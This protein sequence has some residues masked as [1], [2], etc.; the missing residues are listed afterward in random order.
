MRLLRLLPVV[1]AFLILLSGLLVA[2]GSI[3][4]RMN[5]IRIEQKLTDTGLA[6]NAPPIVAFTTVALG[7]FRGLVADWLWLRAN[8]MQEAGNYFE[9]VQLASWITKLQPRFTG[10]TSY[11]AW[12]MAYNVSVTF[13][14][15]ED[16]WRWVRRGVELIRDEALEYNPGDPELYRELG[17][18]YQ[19]KMGQE[20]DDA[21][22]YYK[23]EMAREMVKLFGP[24]PPDWQALADSPTTPAGLR[25]LLGDDHALWGL[26]AKEAKTLDDLE[27]EFVALGEF[28]DAM[29]EP[30]RRAR[31]ERVL[32][33]YFRSRWMGRVYKLDPARIARLN[34]L[35]GDLDWRLPQAHAVYWA[36]RGL[37]TADERVS[38]SCQR[39]I[40]Q[41]LNAAFK[42]GRLIYSKEL[43]LL[44]MT[45]NIALVD[46]VDQAYL[47]AGDTHGQRI[48]RG[49]YENF[50]VDAVV[51]LY[52]FGRTEKA[53]E[54][55]KKGR[56]RFGK[57]FGAPLD[58]FV[59]K[60]L[61]EDVAMA[62]Y[63]Q[64]QAAVQ[65]Y[66]LQTCTALVVGD[67][68]RAAMLERIAAGIWKKYMDDI[69]ESTV[70]RR[71]LPPFAQMKRNQVRQ[72]LELF[73]PNLAEVL[74]RN[75]P[76][77]FDPQVDEDAPPPPER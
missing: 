30:L 73:P 52:T 37:E 34:R 57:R 48:V 76:E 16:R 10:A 64:A 18:I 11:L 22:R 39:M 19:H 59:L 25:R 12:N 24:Y 4:S 60:E 51:I 77:G 47:S 55:L 65:A 54:Y 67:V 26:L 7:G 46:G 27:G 32:E 20:L 40:F 61:T 8:R 33:L 49:G 74:R 28:P 72:C 21:N 44:E 1:L 58:Q 35:H 5:A 6:E 3:Q 36:S 9:L 43:N 69:G 62:S 42:Q 50:L 17:W 13:N 66:I 75:L 14:N 15:P 2:I 38:L 56:D 41:A 70:D 53:G 23:T 63:P 68:E 71:G 29:L 31:V 45:P